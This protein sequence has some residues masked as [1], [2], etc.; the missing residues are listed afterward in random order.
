MD[1]KV[2]YAMTAF[3]QNGAAS[4]L[5]EKVLPRIQT[6]SDMSLIQQ[7]EDARLD[8][9]QKL[10]LN[11]PDLLDLLD[12]TRF[13]GE[14]DPLT[15]ILNSFVGKPAEVIRALIDAKNPAEVGDALKVLFSGDPLEEFR[16]LVTTIRPFLQ[17]QVS[18]A[19]SFATTLENLRDPALWV[20]IP[21]AHIAYF[22]GEQGFVTVDG[23]PILPPMHFG[24]ATLVDPRNVKVELDSLKGLLSEKTA[25]R[26][27][28]DLIRITVEAAADGQYRLRS[29]HASLLGSGNEKQ[30][31]KAARWFKGV[32]SMAESLVT[33]A[34]EEAILGVAQFQ[35][36]ALIAAS[37]GTYAGTAARK[38]A[39]H[40]FLSEIGISDL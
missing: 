11:V 36:N 26:Y 14:D 8:T 28:R 29:R 12:L 16:S 34:V 19:L 35:T 21:Q 18:I 37:A 5:A 15:M 25:E 4:M 32:G 17:R 9:P 3:I 27:I 30:Q 22:F 6:V 31:A 24:G 20:A 40:V 38:A 13:R 7:L 10:T 23:I 1:H 39:Q 2:G 33:S